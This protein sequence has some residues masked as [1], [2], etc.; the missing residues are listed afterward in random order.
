[1][2]NN[3]YWKYLL[4][5]IFLYPSCITNDQNISNFDINFLMMIFVDK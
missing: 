5:F 2:I 4:L 3:F 1:M